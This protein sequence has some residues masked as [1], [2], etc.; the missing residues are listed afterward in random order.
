MNIIENI[1]K[2]KKSLPG[3]VKL[4]AVTKSVSPEVITTVY[5][6]G[7]KIFGENKVQELT[8]KYE[9]LPKD[10]EWQFNGH[11]QRNKVKFLAPFVSMI[12]GVKS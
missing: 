11:M 12:H 3:S 4:V 2:I 9:Q 10:I 1:T 7:H 6:A 5:D 8:A